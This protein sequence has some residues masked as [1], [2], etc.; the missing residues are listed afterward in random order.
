M[1]R[2]RSALVAEK[3]FLRKQLAFYREREI[4]PRRLTDVAR[5]CLLGE[6]RDPDRMAPQRVSA[7]LKVKIENRTT[8]SASQHSPIDCRDGHGES[9]LGTGT[10]GPRAGAQARHLRLTAYGTRLLAGGA[11]RVRRSP[12]PLTALARFRP[13]SRPGDPFLRLLGGGHGAISPASM[14][15]S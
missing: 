3:L 1:F 11:D 15:W 2:S 13:Q 7:F 5:L 14:C 8:T 4:E 6:T 12:H 10:R 9:D